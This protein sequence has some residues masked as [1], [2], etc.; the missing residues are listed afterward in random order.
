MAKTMGFGLAR[1]AHYIYWVPGVLGYDDSVVKYQYD[2]SKSKQL[3]AEAGYPNGIDVSLDIIARDPDRK[4]A[5]MAKFMWDAVGI[6]TTIDAAERAAGLARYQSGN[7]TIGF[8]NLALLPDPDLFAPKALTCNAMN[9]WTNWCNKDFDACI[10]EGGAILDQQKRD[11]IYKRCLKIMMQ[12]DFVGS[13]YLQTNFTAYVN[14]VKGARIHY[15]DA[16]AR[17]VWFDK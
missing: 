6:R 13:G 15:A 12:E 10:A 7:F 1:A 8:Y 2:Q 16:E 4:I 11:D 9:N 5:E 3:L 14:K 17:W